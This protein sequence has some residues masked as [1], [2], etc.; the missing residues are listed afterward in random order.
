MWD[1]EFG[2]WVYRDDGGQADME[3]DAAPGGDGGKANGGGGLASL[4][5]Q[6]SNVS[7]T[8]KSMRD[9]VDAEGVG[10][11]SLKRAKVDETPAQTAQRTH[12]VVSLTSNAGAIS[13]SSSSSNSANAASIARIAEIC[14]LL[15]QMNQLDIYDKTCAD[16]R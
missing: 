11:P 13:S 3:V 5:R 6:E 12:S 2:E 16:I 8:G 15:L 7:Y 1:A 9:V 10:E 4:G 14:N